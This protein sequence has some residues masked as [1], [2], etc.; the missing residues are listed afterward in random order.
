MRWDILLLHNL[1]DQKFLTGLELKQKLWAHA[2]RECLI[3][4]VIS[5][6]RPIQ[7][8]PL[9]I[10]ERHQDQQSA[11]EFGHFHRRKDLLQLFTNPAVDNVPIEDL[12]V[13]AK[14]FATKSVSN[15]Q[16]LTNEARDAYT[17]IHSNIVGLVGQAGIGK[18]ALTKVILKN[19]VE[20]SLYGA[21]YVFYLK[22]RDFDYAT[23]TD[24]LSLLTPAIALHWKADSN[25]RNNVINA[26][27]QNGNVLVILDGFDEVVKD[28]TSNTDYRINRHS[29]AFPLAFI[30]QIL[31]GLIFSKWKKIVTSRPRQLYHLSQDFRPRF[32]LNVLGLTKKA[33]QQLCNDICEQNS[34]RIFQ[35]VQ[36]LPGI[37]A[38]CYVPVNCILVFYSISKTGI[39]STL[40]PTMAS[41]FAH[42]FALFLSTRHAPRHFQLQKFAVLAY[43]VFQSDSFYF[44][45]TDLEQVGLLGEEQNAFLSNRSKNLVALVTGTP[46][47]VLYFTHLLFEESLVAINLLFFMALSDFTKLFIG[48]KLFGVLNLTKPAYDLTESRF[49]NIVRFLFGFCNKT[50]FSYLKETFSFLAFPEQQA[51]LLQQFAL[52]YQPSSHE[53]NYLEKHLVVFTWVYE[54]NDSQFTDRFSSRLPD[55]IRFN[56]RKIL[57]SDISAIHYVLGARKSPLK[58][59][60]YTSQLSQEAFGQFLREMKP[61]ITTSTVVKVS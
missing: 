35:Y 45:E 26:L 31:G 17:A 7:I 54:M 51:R 37:V 38:Y 52:D 60:I 56:S 55:L 1:V 4:P 19:V 47:H 46:S 22:C 40:S 21:E 11:D 23:K 48:T 10:A 24:L 25:R 8:A 34:D 30:N 49:E 32:I 27:A 5:L 50:T 14:E 20:N 59:I 16:H 9:Q 29:Q 28:R 36:S 57:P 39:N 13:K 6:N 43:R 61:M 15:I 58:F 42:A 3:D 33:Q 41:I 2:R 53:F 18:T 44:D 12:F